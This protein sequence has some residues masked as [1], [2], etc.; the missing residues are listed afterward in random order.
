MRFRAFLYIS[1]I[2]L[3]LQLS[4]RP[5]RPGSQ[6]FTQPDGSTFTATC[7]GD[8][9][10]KIIKTTDGHA[11]IRDEDGWWCYATYEADGSKTSSGIR[12]GSGAPTEILNRS[13]DIPYQL[14]NARAQ[15]LRSAGHSENAL[16]FMQRIS[17]ATKSQTKATKHGLVILAQYR[18]VHFKHTRKDFVDMLTKEGYDRNGAKGSAMEYFNAQFGNSVDFSF[19]V[20]EIVT[21]PNDRKYYGENN[22]YGQDARPAEMIYDAC[23]GADPSIDF[24]LYD[25]DNDGY[26][27]NVFVFFAGGD[28]AELFEQE[29]LIWSH[30]WYMES[31]GRLALELDGKSI[32]RYACTAEL[33]YNALAGIGTFCHEY[34]HTFG[35]PDFYDTDYDENGLSAGL[36]CWTSLM[37]G[38]NM[39]DHSN[40]PPFYNAIERELLDIADP[41]PI[42]RNGTY[43]LKPLHSSNEFYRV[44]TETSGLYYLIECRE[45]SGWDRYIKGSGMLIYKVDKTPKRQKRW[46]ID[47]TVN[48]Y[49]DQQCADLVEADGRNDVFNSDSEYSRAIQDITG[50]FFPNEAAETIELT[51]EISMTSIRMNGKNVVFSIVG[52]SE[53][54]IPPTPINLTIDPFMDAAIVSF[55]SDRP[56]DGEAEIR[57]GKAGQEDECMSVKPYETG[58]YA[59]TLEGLIPGNKTY[60]VIVSFEMDGITGA[61]KKKSFM[62][63][64]TVPVEWAY[65]YLGQ[66]ANTDGTYNIGTKIPLRVYNADGAEEIE[67][68]FNGKP[69]S[70]AGDGYYTIKERGVLRA[71]VYWSGGGTDILE[72]QIIL[73][74]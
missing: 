6:T 63:K 41:I 2:F 42:E 28:E 22:Y 33:S 68:E 37:D 60:T 50:I 31:G 64:R 54:I 48:A 55:E 45:R 13:M 58:K 59:V 17:V 53:A 27:D 11:I 47:N 73:S 19:E 10:M 38:G 52:F 35:L 70:P 34:S 5:A 65:I 49:A 29:D 25:D 12:I 7:V 16:P 9:F 66:N 15:E 72:K 56:F 21:L 69:I 40:T 14:L 23:I 46:V 67:W 26:V 74:E 32:D 1:I 4:A 51:P 39:N 20:S 36:W 18:N 71:T 44:N 43:T 24:S 3:T 61:E 62:T 8:E 57:W 30:A